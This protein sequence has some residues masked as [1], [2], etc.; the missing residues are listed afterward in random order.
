VVHFLNLSLGY[1]NNPSVVPSESE[2]NTLCFFNDVHE[3]PQAQLAHQ[4]SQE[5]NENIY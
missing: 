2:K 5:N 1:E 4:Q 3:L